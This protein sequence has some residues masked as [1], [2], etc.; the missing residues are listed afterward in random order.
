MITDPAAPGAVIEAKL[1]SGIDDHF[2]YSVIAKVVSRATARGGVHRL[3]SDGTAVSTLRCPPLCLAREF[4]RRPVGC[5]TKPQ[6]CG[7]VP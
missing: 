3:G 1:I 4:E 5:T 6:G 7:G 2:R